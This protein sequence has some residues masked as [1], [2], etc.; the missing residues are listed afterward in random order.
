[1]TRPRL[2]VKAVLIVLI[3]IIATSTG[4][5][6]GN[7][8]IS[9]QG[10]YSDSSGERIVSA[11]LYEQQQ[12]VIAVST[13]FPEMAVKINRQNQDLFQMIPEFISFI[14]PDRLQAMILKSDSL[15]TE[16]LK[17]QDGAESGGIYAGD[18]FD[19]AGKEWSCI[20]P[21]NEFIDYFFSDL[22]DSPEYHGMSGEKDLVFNTCHETIKKGADDLDLQVIARKYEDG[23]YDVLSIMAREGILATVSIDRS[24]EKKLRT[25]IGYKTE[26]RYYYRDLNFMWETNSFSVETALYSGIE[27]SYRSLAQQQPLFSETLEIIPAG[28]SGLSVKATFKTRTLTAPLIITGSVYEAA[29]GYAQIDFHA[30][31]SDHNDQQVHIYAFMEEQIRPVAFTDKRITDL[32]DENDS[33]IFLKEINSGFTALI[34]DII[35]KLPVDYQRLIVNMIIN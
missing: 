33:D 29:D 9:L 18:V 25:L 4:Y 30:V 14:Q 27:S 15:L 21:L 1:M 8:H 26:G 2:T 24:Q 3:I 28:D 5:A 6:A 22:K 7:G 20:F 11:D 31:P 35:P 19:H 17:G 10:S 16:W 12:E 23:T 34:T 32:L 13:L